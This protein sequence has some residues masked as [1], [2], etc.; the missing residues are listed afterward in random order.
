[1]EQCL[2]FFPFECNRVTQNWN[3]TGHFVSF[4]IVSI[5]DLLMESAGSRALAKKDWTLTICDL[6]LFKDILFLFFFEQAFVV[7]KKCASADLETVL[8]FV[9]CLALFTCLPPDRQ[10]CS[11]QGFLLLVSL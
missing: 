1:M 2:Y 5:M 4:W 7:D 6:A 11:S 9:F 10:Q 3:L 8:R